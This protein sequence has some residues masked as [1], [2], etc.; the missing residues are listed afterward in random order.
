MLSFHPP[1]IYFV[2][3]EEEN[4][5]LNLWLTTI[6]T[7]NNLNLEHIEFWNIIF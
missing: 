3:F 6:Q 4:I 5:D 7:P 2:S 1:I